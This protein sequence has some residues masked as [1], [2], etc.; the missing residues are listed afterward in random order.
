MTLS[1]KWQQENVKLVVF[2]GYPWM[3]GSSPMEV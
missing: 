2:F 1:H 3:M